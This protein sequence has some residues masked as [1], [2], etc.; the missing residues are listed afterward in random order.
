MRYFLGIVGILGFCD[1]FYFSQSSQYFDTP[2]L[3]F[4]FLRIVKRCSLIRGL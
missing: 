1:F 3:Y 4:V 2:I